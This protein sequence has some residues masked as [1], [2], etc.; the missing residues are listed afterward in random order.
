MIWFQKLL[1]LLLGDIKRKR[2]KYRKSKRCQPIDS[3][4]L[5]H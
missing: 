1:L 2:L 5:L 3:A 4:L